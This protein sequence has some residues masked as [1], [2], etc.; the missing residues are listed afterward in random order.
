MRGDHRLRLERVPGSG[1]L[2]KHLQW[3]E[4]G[5]QAAG[6]Q[7]HQAGDGGIAIQDLAPLGVLRLVRS[8][9]DQTDFR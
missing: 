4:Q 1:F 6:A 3:T 5:F 9:L 2:Q 7:Q 8:P